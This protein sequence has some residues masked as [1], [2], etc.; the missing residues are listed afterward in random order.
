MKQAGPFSERT[1]RLVLAIIVTDL[2]LQGAETIPAFAEAAET[3]HWAG[4]GT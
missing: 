3:F 2:L 4:V 1:E